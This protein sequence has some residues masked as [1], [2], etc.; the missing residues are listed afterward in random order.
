MNNLHHCIM[1]F[2]LFFVLACSTYSIICV[3]TLDGEIIKKHENIG[4]SKVFRVLHI[5]VFGSLG[6]LWRGWIL[7]LLDFKYYKKKK[8][9][10][11]KPFCEI[12]VWGFHG[13]GAG[14]K[15]VYFCI[16]QFR[17]FMEGLD[18]DVAWF[19]VLQKEKSNCI[20]IILH[21]HRLGFLWGGLA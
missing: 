7:T 10:L 3:P 9:I 18:S 2:K 13:R 4:I 11:L 15:L 14:I 12:S 19:S 21:N 1:H 20:E 6:S 16:W 17:K 5:F 8:L